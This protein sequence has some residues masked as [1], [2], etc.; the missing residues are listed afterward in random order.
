MEFLTSTES[1][2]RNILE[3]KLQTR[4]NDDGRLRVLIE[5]Y[6][7]VNEIGEQK[8]IDE[9]YVLIETYWNVNLRKSLKT[10]TL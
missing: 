10:Q 3:C 7:N 2:N 8:I 6:W 5:T 4:N 1:L 9:K